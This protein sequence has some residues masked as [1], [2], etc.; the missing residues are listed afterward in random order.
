MKVKGR[1]LINPSTATA[2]SEQNWNT[3]RKQTKIKKLSFHQRYQL[4]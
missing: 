1:I 4:I 2:T 3:F